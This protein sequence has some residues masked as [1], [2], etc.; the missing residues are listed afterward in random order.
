MREIRNDVRKSKEKGLLF[1]FGA[2]LANNFNGLH[3]R[4]SYRHHLDFGFEGADEG[5]Y[6]KRGDSVIIKPE[7]G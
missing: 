1:Q 6:Q 2:V 7:K 4:E 3:G 5:V